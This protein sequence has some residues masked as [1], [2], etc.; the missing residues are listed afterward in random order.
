MVTILV[1]DVNDQLPLVV[2]AKAGVIAAT[3]PTG[4]R[5]TL[6]RAVDL[7]AG[8]NGSVGFRLVD[9]GGTDDKKPQSRGHGDSE[10]FGL[11]IDGALYLRRSLPDM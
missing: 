1:K 6:L 5:V 11:G 9:G 4:T 10:Y 8:V 2:S 7:D 3:D